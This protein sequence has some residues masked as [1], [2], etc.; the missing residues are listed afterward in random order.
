M[1]PTEA[2]V[3]ELGEIANEFGSTWSYCLL[4]IFEPAGGWPVSGNPADWIY[5]CK[6]PAYSMGYV[7][8]Y[9]CTFPMYKIVWWKF[10]HFAEEAWWWIRYYLWGKW[11]PTDFPWDRDTTDKE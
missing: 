8:G 7:P 5:E 1:E 6:L 9:I 10:S 4:E 11:R 2:T 3:E